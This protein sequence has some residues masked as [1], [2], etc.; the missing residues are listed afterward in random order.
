MEAVGQL[1]N[2]SRSGLSVRASE[3]PRAGAIIALQFESP[4]GKLVDV[5]GEVRWNARAS[6]TAPRDGF[7]VRLHEPPRAYREFVA[8]ALSRSEKCEEDGAEDGEL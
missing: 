1:V 8:W 7:G 4:V 5:R 2:V 6:S 3:L